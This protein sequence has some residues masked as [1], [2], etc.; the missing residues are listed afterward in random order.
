MEAISSSPVWPQT[1]YDDLIEQTKNHPKAE[2]I[3]ELVTHI[4][5][6]YQQWEEKGSI[7]ATAYHQLSPQW[8]SLLT[9]QTRYL[10]NPTPSILSLFSQLPLEII[11]LHQAPTSNDQPID[12]AT[13]TTV[14]P[15]LNHFSKL[16]EQ[17]VLDLPQYTTTHTT[18][19]FFA[20]L[21]A[22]FLTN[23]PYD[24]QI[25][26]SNE[27]TF[28]LQNKDYPENWKEIIPIIKEALPIQKRQP[29]CSPLMIATCRNEFVYEF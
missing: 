7:N 11:R 1:V 28:S 20:Y 9:E 19:G 10:T 12:H 2:Q 4:F 22:L 27:Q 17:V 14:D 24:D 6:C 23:Q 18:D 3:R 21:F 8:N 25:L 26:I 29:Q 13:T 5:Y 16:A 15:W